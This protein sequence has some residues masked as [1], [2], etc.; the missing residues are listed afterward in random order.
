MFFVMLQCDEHVEINKFL[1]SLAC[2]RMTIIDSRVYI[3]LTANLL[4]FHWNKIINVNI[5][6]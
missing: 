3:K 5:F 1:C 4:M 2:T 6:F